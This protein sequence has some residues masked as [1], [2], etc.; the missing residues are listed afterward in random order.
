MS[1]RTVLPHIV[2][3]DAVATGQLHRP[4]KCMRV[5]P[6]GKHD[7]VHLVQHTIIG[8]DAPMFDVIDTGGD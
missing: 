3:P 6:R 1:M 2:D 8:D 5:K 7:D 4:E